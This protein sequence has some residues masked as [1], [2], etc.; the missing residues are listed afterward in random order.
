MINFIFNEVKKRITSLN[1]FI[2]TA[3]F[4]FIKKKK[5]F[6]SEKESTR[7]IGI[8]KSCPNFSSGMCNICGCLMAAKT[9]F[10]AAKCPDEKNP[11][12]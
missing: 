3:L 5:L 1:K 2:H 9:K 8:C 4:L 10:Y 7:R 12:W 6:V 11:R